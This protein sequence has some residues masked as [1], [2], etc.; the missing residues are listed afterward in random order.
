MFLTKFDM[1]QQLGTSILYDSS[2]NKQNI[3]KIRESTSNL[4]GALKR[5]FGKIF[6]M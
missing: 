2:C 3:T 6:V 1:V 5:R 4:K